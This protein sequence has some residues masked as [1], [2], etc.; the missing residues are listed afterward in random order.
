MDTTTTRWG[1]GDTH[2]LQW[3][4]M[5]DR[6]IAQ[7]RRS[8]RAVR[9]RWPFPDADGRCARCGWRLAFVDMST[10]DG[11]VRPHWRHVRRPRLSTTG[12]L[13]THLIGSGRL[14]A[15]PL[16]LES[17]AAWKASRSQWPLDN[18]ADNRQQP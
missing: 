12:R 8:A 9:C 18:N 15:V 13:N 4:E 10:K 17:W 3:L 2:R 16:T 1:F 14:S 11:P 6:L 7:C 5:R